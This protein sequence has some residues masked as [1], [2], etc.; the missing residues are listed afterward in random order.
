VP[1]PLKE[2]N[3]DTWNN[4]EIASYYSALTY[5]T[6]CERV[7]FDEYLHVGMAILDLGV[8]GGRT[9]PYLSSIASRYVGA[10]YAA[11]MVAVCQ[12]KF[13]N[14]EFQ[15]V[16]AADLSRFPAAGFDTV[17]MAYN[18]IDNLMP[19]E[20]RGRAWGHM[21][22]VLK[23]QGVL[24]FSSH[25]PR[26]ILV[27]PSWNPKRLET[28]AKRMAGESLLYWPLL[29][30]LTPVRVAIAALQSLVRSLFRVAKRAPTRAFWL[31]EGYLMDSA[32]GGTRIHY[33]TPE[34]VERELA[35]F[36]F[37]LLRILGDDYPRVS[38]SL[39]TDWYYYVFARSD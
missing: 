38:R 15:T 3:L 22:R 23:P 11:E 12:K 39:V 13:P 7:L 14:L 19:N 18:G 5:L 30:G 29:W 25:N 16:D 31:G 26:S 4:P 24:I 9:T 28:L 34:K 35:R 2:T 21:H 8:G 36:G 10:D 1:K 6:P 20:S 32:H 17:V 33:S 27:R 37:R